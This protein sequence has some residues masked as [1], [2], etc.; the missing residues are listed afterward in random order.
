MAT[1]PRTKTGVRPSRV[2]HAWTPPDWELADVAAFQALNRGAASAEQQ[3]RALTWLLYKAAGVG[4]MPFRPGGVEGER[5][6][7]FAL[8]RLFVGQQVAKMMKLD[9]S[10]LKPREARADP[11]EDQ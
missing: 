1:P 8:G 5:E 10:L 6:T 3:V 4:D 7:N 11:H 2:V 9:L